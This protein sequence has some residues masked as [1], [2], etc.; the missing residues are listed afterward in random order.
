MQ[1]LATLSLLAVSLTFAGTSFA[2]AHAQVLQSDGTMAQPQQQATPAATAHKAPNSAH[3]LKHL[4]KQLSLTPDQTS[5]LQPILADRD[6][7]MATLT[8]NTSLDPKSVH[9]QRHA[10]ETDTESKINAVLTPD[11]Q[12]L[13]ADM[14]AARHHGGETPVV[15]PTA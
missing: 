4:R 2:A 7:R 11:Q 3:Q 10:I 15:P 12:K 6:T 1:S 14:R 9:Q 13:Y 5:K 8:G